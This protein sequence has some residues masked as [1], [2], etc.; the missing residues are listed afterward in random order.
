MPVVCACSSNRRSQR[1]CAPP[2][3]LAG[4]ACCD[5]AHAQLLPKARPAASTHST[6]VC[7]SV[8]ALLA[9]ALQTQTHTDPRQSH[10]THV[11]PTAH[12]WA[13]THTTAGHTSEP[14]TEFSPHAFSKAQGEHTHALCAAAAV[15]WA[16]VMLPPG[17]R[18]CGALR[19]C[20]TATVAWDALQPGAGSALAQQQLADSRTQ[21][22]RHTCTHTGARAGCCRTLLLGQA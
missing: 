8:H 10:Q 12:L 22:H 7:C 18:G 9:E 11:L 2:A 17:S 1:S 15:P 4:H 21:A 20:K 5:A 19:A 3:S 13:T 16:A 14:Q 6:M